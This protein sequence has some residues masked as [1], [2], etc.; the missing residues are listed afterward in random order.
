MA[1]ALP[2]PTLESMFYGFSKLNADT[3]FNDGKTITLPQSDIWMKQSKVFNKNITLTDTGK[4][5]FKFK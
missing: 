2:M 3:D 5:F 1:E 4:E